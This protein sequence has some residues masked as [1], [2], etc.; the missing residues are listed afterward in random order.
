MPQESRSFFTPPFA[1]LM[2]VWTLGSILL[3]G[4]QK[5]GR[6]PFS[7]V[8]GVE[9]TSGIGGNPEFIATNLD[10]HRGSTQKPCDGLVGVGPEQ[11]DF[12]TCPPDEKGG[13]TE[14][15]AFGLDAR[16]GP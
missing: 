15:L 3:L 14:L 5:I 9:L 10:R 2:F 7:R 1:A 13:D 11:G 12:R 6:L 16:R 4:G 8:D